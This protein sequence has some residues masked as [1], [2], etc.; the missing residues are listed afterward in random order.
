VRLIF[1][2]G[3]DTRLQADGLIEQM[4]QLEN[5]LNVRLLAY[6]SGAFNE[7][8]ISLQKISID[9]LSIVKLYDSIITFVL[10]RPERFD[11]IEEKPAIC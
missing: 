10:Q 6:Y 3:T 2:C 9:L 4:E 8:S 7:T 5:C 11:E 1:R